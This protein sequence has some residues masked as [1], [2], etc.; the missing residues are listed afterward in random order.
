[1]CGDKLYLFI[2]FPFIAYTC[3]LA[4]TV[5]RTGRIFTS[6]AKLYFHSP[7][8]H[9]KVI[10]PWSEVDS[11]VIEKTTIDSEDRGVHMEFTARLGSIHGEEAPTLTPTPTLT[12]ALTLVVP[13]L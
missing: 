6:I 11:L 8:Y 1:M 12:L 9:T 5:E 4:R 7:K 13:F 3:I 2:F 10:I